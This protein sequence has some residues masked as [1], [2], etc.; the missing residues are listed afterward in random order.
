VI[1]ALDA[2]QRGGSG[3]S[4]DVIQRLVRQLREGKT[5]SDALAADAEFPPLLVALVKASEL[6]S[7]LPET[8]AHFLE[9]EQRVSEVRHRLTST[10]IYPLLLMGVGSLV[11]LFLLFYVMPRFARVFEGMSGDLP[12]SA[13]VM[14]AWSH[15]L[16]DYRGWWLA[17][18]LLVVLTATAMLSSSSLR[19]RMAQRLL[20]WAPLQMRLSTYFLSRW[21]RATGML[22]QGGIPL[23]QALQLAHDLLP[24]G[25]QAGG[26]AVQQA[27]NDGLSPSAAHVRAGM[28][29]PVAE[30]LL[31][32]GERTGDL[33]TV[34]MRIAHF[35]ESELSRTLERT[36]RTLEP[37]V[38]VL[39]GLGVGL[40]VILMYL[41]IFELAAAIQ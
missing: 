5:F 41:P 35:H 10:A 36:M 30:Q 11:L 37:V 7:D 24:L 25:L 39:I 16:A 31:R 18:M 2:L 4:V 33:G 15:W 28:A 38:M 1:E 40:V 17:G 29:T 27:V 13:R 14:V 6:T 32:A 26:R 22:V 34:L 3:A 20:A 12:W 8:L 9:H 23:P 21:Y 19:S